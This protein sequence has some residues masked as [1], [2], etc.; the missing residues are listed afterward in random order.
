MTHEKGS[1][2]SENPNR[3]SGKRDHAD[4]EDNVPFK[5]RGRFLWSDDVN[6][7]T[8]DKTESSGANNNDRKVS[9][10]SGLTDTGEENKM[11]IIPNEKRSSCITCNEDDFSESL[12]Q[13]AI[14][15][16]EGTGNEPRG[17]GGGKQAAKESKELMDHTAVGGSGSCSET[18]TTVP[19]TRSGRNIEGDRRLEEVQEVAMNDGS[20]ESSAPGGDE[21]SKGDLFYKR[22]RA[23]QSSSPDKKPPEGESD[24]SGDGPD[25]VCVEKHIH[26][27]EGGGT[28]DDVGGAFS[29]TAFESRGDRNIEDERHEE[30]QNAATKDGE[31]NDDGGE[32]RKDETATESVNDCSGDAPDVVGDEEHIQAEGGTK[33]DDGG[34]DC[35]PT[36]GPTVECQADRIDEAQET[37]VKGGKDETAPEGED[38]GG[39]G[40]FSPTNTI[41]ESD[42]G[43]NGEGD[44]EEQGK[45]AA[46]EDDGLGSNSNY[47]PRSEEPMEGGEKPLDYVSTMIHDGGHDCSD[48]ALGD[49]KQAQEPELVAKHGGGSSRSYADTTAGSSEGDRHEQGQPAA[50]EDGGNKNIINHEPGVTEQKN[51]GKEPVEADHHEQ[52]R[53][54]AI[55]DGGDE[56]TVDVV[57]GEE[58]QK[59]KKPV[60]HVTSRK[61]S[62]DGGR[63]PTT[64]L[65]S[66]EGDHDEQIQQ[67]A[68]EVPSDEIRNKNADANSSGNITIQ[69]DMQTQQDPVT[70]IDVRKRGRSCHEQASHDVGGGD[71][72]GQEA[73]KK[74]KVGDVGYSEPPAPQANHT[75]L[76]F[77]VAI[78]CEEEPA[79]G[80]GS[81]SDNHGGE[82]ANSS[83]PTQQPTDGIQLFGVY[84]TGEQVQPVAMQGIQLFGVYI[85][86][87]QVPSVAMQNRDQGNIHGRGGSSM[88]RPRSGLRL[89][90]FDI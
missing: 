10:T 36:A 35:T 62:Q 49:G 47:A 65:V 59:G 22:R 20:D 38:D 37:A 11:E 3:F 86:G 44:R 79:D 6:E 61:D 90:G 40:S 2:E 52:E 15:E 81:G 66:S 24:F 76:L 58:L 57:S 30:A 26:K 68:F 14:S 1:E 9:S 46:M 23:T 12:P 78:P 27:A 16:S 51:K 82:S 77:G 75:F 70:T 5:K 72:Q 71:T 85:T 67:A 28:S 7:V 45:H 42:N 43:G 73:R 89:F 50:M 55:E 4:G 83:P 18:G 69:V 88:Q 64:F 41:T 19:P 17:D 56:N 87:E 21:Q 53:Q 32:C 80:L 39:N 54:T 13:L 25:V 34:G 31:M 63:D 74:F 60:E 33:H 8:N 29:P 48:N 84:M